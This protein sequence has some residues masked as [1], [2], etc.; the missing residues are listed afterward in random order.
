M[1][2]IPANNECVNNEEQ[3]KSYPLAFGK[4]IKQTCN[5]RPLNV[6]SLIQ[7]IREPKVEKLGAFSVGEAQEWKSEDLPYFILSKSIT[8]KDKYIMEEDSF[9]GIWLDWDEGC[10]SLD[11][12]KERLNAL[13]LQGYAIWS[14]LKHK[15]VDSESGE[16]Y[17]NRFRVVVIFSK[18]IGC[19]L[20]LKFSHYLFDRLGGESVGL[21]K[22]SLSV[23]QGIF[24]PVRTDNYE[25]YLTDNDL[26]DPFDTSHPFVAAAQKYTLIEKQR[27]NKKT[28]SND[29]H[30]GLS[31]AITKQNLDS[32]I[33]WFNSQDIAEV[34][35]QCDFDYDQSTNRW[36]PPGAESPHGVSIQNNK[37]FSHHANHA[38]SDGR[39][40]SCFDVLME[41]RFNDCFES[42]LEAVSDLAKQAGVLPPDTP[43]DATGLEEAFKPFPVISGIQLKEIEQPPKFLIQDWLAESE[44]GLLLGNSQA[45][46][47]FVMLHMAFCVATGKPFGNLKVDISGPV[48]F[49]IGEGAKGFRKRV[50]ALMMEHGNTN[51]IHLVQASPCLSQLEDMRR[52][53]ATLDEIK[54]VL[55]VVDTF[56]SLSG[57]SDE[58]SNSQVANV[59]KDVRALT[60]AAIVVVH[61]Y[62]KDDSRGGRGASAF[63]ANVDF[64]WELVRIANSL[65]TVLSSEKMKDGPTAS[66]LTFELKERPLLI[67]GDERGSTSLVV[68][69]IKTS[70]TRSAKTQYT[71]NDKSVLLAIKDLDA[72]R[73]HGGAT[74]TKHNGRK[75]LLLPRKDVRGWLAHNGYTVV[76]DGKWP[77]K[78][79]QAFNRAIKRLQS[80]GVIGMTGTGTQN[81]SVFL[82][83]PK[84]LDFNE[85][86]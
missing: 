26:L 3:A 79:N 6:V 19:E 13:G 47:S 61:H 4:K 8:R 60:E 65:K 18:P 73:R 80:D 59:L 34:L 72:D 28:A 43:A 20:Y 67:E 54:P 37:V 7:Q 75:V 9:I 62:G 24:L 46:K 17:G 58:N 85:Y 53:K 30:K 23:S 39:A 68:E 69:E 33:D 76:E 49:V 50:R 22:K 70:N 16:F 29:S 71:V 63:L 77:N 86:K 38:L 66:E 82:Y 32:P 41:Y 83:S 5:L 35:K 10:P 12:I 31:P 57:V 78:D 51:N 42:T 52:L 40:H 21:D 84:V 27:D 14:T 36:R 25:Y 56:S 55:L 74:L 48:V 45:F 64:V 11:E 2:S 15:L 81:S 44:I 1:Q